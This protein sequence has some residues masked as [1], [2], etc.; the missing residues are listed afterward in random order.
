MATVRRFYTSKGCKEQVGYMGYDSQGN[1]GWIG[2]SQFRPCGTSGRGG[3]D[4]DGETPTIGIASKGNNPNMER[5]AYKKKPTN[6]TAVIGI[7]D[8]KE[9]FSIVDPE[10]EVYY[11]EPTLEPT[12]FEKYGLWV[13]VIGGGLIAYFMFKK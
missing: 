13:V 8:G 4:A 2:M 12:F 9:P 1:W 10:K 7:G 5:V 3:T 11:S 6:E